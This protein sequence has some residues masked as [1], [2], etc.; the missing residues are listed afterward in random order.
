M[1][2][3]GS[4]LEKIFAAREGIT[5]KQTMKGCCCDAKNEWTVHNYMSDYAHYDNSGDEIMF[6]AE[7]G[8]CCLRCLSHFAPGFRP[9]CYDVWC[10]SH[11]RSS[12]GDRPGF[13]DT[14][15]TH[16]KKCTNGVACWIGEGDGGPLRIPCCCNLPYLETMDHNRETLGKTQ[17]IC[18]KNLC[19]PK[20]DVLGPN[21]ERWY[22]IR[23]DTCCGDCLP[24]IQ[25]G[26]AKG[27]CCAIPFHIREPNP[28]FA[29]LMGEKGTKE[30]TAQITNLWSGLKE[31]CNR[32]NYALHFP[33]GA[34]PAQKATLMGSVFLIDMVNFEQDQA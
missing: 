29:Y 2:G 7:R 14:M 33:D 22:R 34:T 26:G 6:A 3:K 23:P 13:S 11:S 30:Q 20:Y 10:G 32:Q 8:G 31:C 25:C 21:G 19:V 4:D 24:A 16:E 12:D 1:G 15:L 27:R 5:L 9:S 17:Y 18:D 28:P